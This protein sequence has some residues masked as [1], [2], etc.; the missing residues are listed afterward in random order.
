MIKTIYEKPIKTEQTEPGRD[1]I[2]LAERLNDC[3][4][5]AERL[6]TSF[7]RIMVRALD[8]D[9]YGKDMTARDCRRSMIRHLVIGADRFALA[10]H[11]LAAGW[12]SDA[13]ML[14]NLAINKEKER[15]GVEANVRRVEED[16]ARIDIDDYRLACYLAPE[17]GM[18]SPADLAFVRSL[19]KKKWMELEFLATDHV[20]A[21]RTELGCMCNRT[22]AL[23]GFAP[24]SGR[25]RCA[26]CRSEWMPKVRIDY[27]A[28][29][30]KLREVL[31]LDDLGLLKRMGDDLQRE[32][33]ARITPEQEA[34]MK[35]PALSLS[36]GTG[37][38]GPP[39]VPLDIGTGTEADKA[40]AAM[41]ALGR[42]GAEMVRSLFIPTQPIGAC[43]AISP[44]GHRC[45][46]DGGNAHVSH[47][48]KANEVDRSVLRAVEGITWKGTWAGYATTP[49]VQLC[50]SHDILGD[51]RC[52][53]QYDHQGMC[54]GPCSAGYVAKWS[55]TPKPGASR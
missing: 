17:G 14:F 16:L 43:E 51:A 13:E 33:I 21:D 34:W 26:N 42:E 29:K 47:W 22:T 46:V 39:E 4:D 8:D 2:G 15:S 19:P 11:V 36:T 27:G 3:G 45:E 37:P 38:P 5:S 48:A 7:A 12:D 18:C 9:E 10:K 23:Q 35:G 40:F 28:V 30:R 52:T 41:K 55:G 32:A 54:S 31:E 6:A 50:G 25:M 20:R 1:K 53:Q 44:Y 24:T 49:L